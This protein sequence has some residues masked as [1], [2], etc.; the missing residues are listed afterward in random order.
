MLTLS[1]AAQ[2]NNNDCLN[3]IYQWSLEGNSLGIT[4]GANNT[5]LYTLT[6]DTDLYTSDEANVV[7]VVTCLGCSKLVKYPVTYVE[8]SNSGCEL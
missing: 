1:Y 6:V 7:L 2:I 8:F 3:P 5:A 4:A